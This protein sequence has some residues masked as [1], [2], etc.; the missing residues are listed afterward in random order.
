MK[1]SLVTM[2]IRKGS[3]ERI[4]AT[5]WM[6][7]EVGGRGDMQP[8]SGPGGRRRGNESSFLEIT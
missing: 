6:G 7:R 1:E 5:M 4:S 3:G 2:G 8:F